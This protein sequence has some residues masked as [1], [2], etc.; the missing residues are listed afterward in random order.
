VYS[1]PIPS[2]S[3]LVAR[4]CSPGHL[5]KRASAS[6]AQPSR[7]CS[8]LSR[9]SSNSVWARSREMVSVR[10]RPGSS[11]IIMAC[12]TACGTRAGSET[13]AS[14][15][16]QTPSPNSDASR[17]ATA[18]A[19]RVLP[20]PPGPVRVSSRT[21]PVRSSSSSATSRSRPTKL[22]NCSGILPC[23]GSPDRRSRGKS[24]NGP[25]PSSGPSPGGRIASDIRPCSLRFS[26]AVWHYIHHALPPTRPLFSFPLKG[27]AT[28][29]GPVALLPS[30]LSGGREVR[31]GILSLR[32]T[33]D[34]QEE[35]KRQGDRSVGGSRGF[36]ASIGFGG[37]GPGW[38]RKRRYRR[39][40]P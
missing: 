38:L 6:G 22:V 34:S 24:I 29:V 5:C 26:R 23:G 36:P 8:Q 10:G 31:S 19:S 17:E 13:G 39:R 32:L 37:R 3:R 9:T 12:A 30:L 40:L 4:M 16:H 27:M 14:S 28:V 33:R 35:Y 25:R 11:L 7:R 20:L 21:F 2:T 1:P 15:T 18:S